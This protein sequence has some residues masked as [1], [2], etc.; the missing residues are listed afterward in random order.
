MIFHLFKRV[1][2]MNDTT[3]NLYREYLEQTDNVLAASNLTLA[4]VMQSMRAEK[5]ARTL[6]INQPLSVTEVAKF[7]RVRPHKVLAWIHSGQLH[8]FNV[9]ANPGGRPKYRIDPEELT[10]FTTRRS[11]VPPTSARPKR[12]IRRLPEITEWPRL[13]KKEARDRGDP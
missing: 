3:W 7:L 10:A 13:P 1:D 4:D 8:A 2:D 9:A 5:P 11:E 12:T 6:I